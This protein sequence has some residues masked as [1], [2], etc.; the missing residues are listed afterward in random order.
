MALGSI[1]PSVPLI[2]AA[3]HPYSRLARR[4]VILHIS[5]ARDHRPLP[6]NHGVGVPLIRKE[7]LDFILSL[8]KENIQRSFL[9]V[10]PHLEQSDKDQRSNT[11][12]LG[13]EAHELEEF[14]GAAIVQ[15]SLSMKMNF[16][17]QRLTPI[18]SPDCT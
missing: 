17:I 1:L 15:I 18:A 11:G 16:A 14:K 6:G 5:P 12:F 4:E 8:S 10:G 2:L 9:L 7:L 13:S 3:T